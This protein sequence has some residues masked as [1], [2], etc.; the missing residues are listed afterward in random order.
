MFIE[1]VNEC[2]T[3]EAKNRRLS[4]LLRTTLRDKAIKKIERVDSDSHGWQVEF[5]N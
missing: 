3:P 5:S 1:D 4:D 2:V